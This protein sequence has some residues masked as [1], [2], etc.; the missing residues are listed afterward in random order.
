MLVGIGGSGKQSLTKLASYISGYKTFQITMTRTYNTANFIED[1]K[2]L[3]RS[4]GIQGKGTTFLFADQDVK[5]E[6]FL[7]YINGVLSGSQIMNLFSRD[8]Q[9]EITNECTPLMRR[10][11]PNISLTTESAIAWF[12]DRVNANFH[13]VLCFSPVGEQFRTRAIKFPGIFSG[14]TINWFQEWPKDALVSVSTHFLNN[15]EIKCSNDVKKNLYTAMAL[16]QDSVSK[17]CR[18][19]FER[20]RRANHVTPKSFLNFIK[21]Y[22]E[23]YVLKRLEIDKT[24]ERINHGLEK[25]SEASA[26]IEMLKCQLSEMEKGLIQANDKSANVLAEAAREAKEAE[27]IKER[28]NANK[29][30]AEQIVIE[31]DQDRQIAEEKLGVAKPALEEAEKALNTIKPSN[32]SAIKKL[33]KPPHLIMRI[34]DSVL[35]LFRVK[36][37]P[38]KLDEDGHQCFKPR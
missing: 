14:C 15:F 22:K 17:A 9:S 25:L 35:I 23:I 28:I 5:E 11:S 4:C 10:E 27:T 33:G 32:I 30:K 8:E 26:R 34:M 7:E 12:L 18:D 13:V 36:L 3:F 21:S 38:P 31:I 24:K 16:V 37:P 20:F 6:G 1:L 2:L 19:Y 29:N